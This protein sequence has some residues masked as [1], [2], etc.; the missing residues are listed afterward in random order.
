[1]LRSNNFVKAVAIFLFNVSIFSNATAID[2]RK[3]LPKLVDPQTV[4]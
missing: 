2:L 4:V 3:K 1:M